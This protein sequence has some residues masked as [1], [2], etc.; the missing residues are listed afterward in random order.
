[1]SQPTSRPNSYQGS[2]FYPGLLCLCVSENKLAQTCLTPVCSGKPQWVI[3]LPIHPELRGIWLLLLLTSLKL[4]LAW[5]LVS[6]FLLNWHSV[7][8]SLRC[9]TDGLGCPYS[10]P[11]ELSCNKLD[12]NTC[13]LEVLLVITKG[14]LPCDL[15]RMFPKW[16]CNNFLEG[17]RVMS[18]PC[19]VRDSHST[20]ILWIWLACYSHQYLIEYTTILYVISFHYSKYSF[21]WWW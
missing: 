10:C 8:H 19:R 17:L 9:I 13:Q 12:F 1:M 18:L 16:P 14:L 7:I 11:E 20:N 2:F 21:C 6:Y 4:P 15:M 3:T 5:L